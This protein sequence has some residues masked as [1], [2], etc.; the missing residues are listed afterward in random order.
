MEE[1]ITDILKYAV[2]TVGASATLATATA[3]TSTNVVLR[4]VYKIIN[5]V[6]MNMGKSKNA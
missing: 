6:G 3:N 1:L 5:V 2:M 4:T